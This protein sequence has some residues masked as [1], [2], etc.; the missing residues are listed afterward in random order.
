MMKRTRSYGASIFTHALNQPFAQSIHYYLVSS[1]LS[2]SCCSAAINHLNELSHDG[3]EQASI[4]DAFESHPEQRQSP[5]EYTRRSRLLSL[6][7][8]L[9]N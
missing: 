5:L 8:N 9:S 3:S 6:L 4:C 1:V 7:I 2:L